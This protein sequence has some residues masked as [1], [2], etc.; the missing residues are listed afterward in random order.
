MTHGDDLK[1]PN[2][3][4]VVFIGRSGISLLNVLVRFCFRGSSTRWLKPN[5]RAAFDE[6]SNEKTVLVL[7]SEPFPYTCHLMPACM[8][9][10]KTVNECPP[11]TN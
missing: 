7:S 10:I 11:G 6:S 3:L 2:S 8:L 9:S 5:K 1:S 4:Y